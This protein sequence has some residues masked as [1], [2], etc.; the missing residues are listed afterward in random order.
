MAEGELKLD[1]RP[2]GADEKRLPDAGGEG[3]GKAEAQQARLAGSE[4]EIALERHF[5]NDLPMNPAP[6]AKVWPASRWRRDR[7][8][9]AVASHN[10]WSDA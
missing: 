1:R 6:A 3:H 10:L 5:P 2:E 8:Y 9:R 7:P 4:A